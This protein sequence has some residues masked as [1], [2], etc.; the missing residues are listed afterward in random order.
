MHW[1]LLRIKSKQMVCRNQAYDNELRSWNRDFNYISIEDSGGLVRSHQF[2]PCMGN[3]I[4][5]SIYFCVLESK[6]AA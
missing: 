1:E 2:L 6:N 4:F 5:I 3:Y